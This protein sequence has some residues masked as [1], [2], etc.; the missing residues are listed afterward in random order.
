MMLMLRKRRCQ[1][2]GSLTLQKFCVL[3]KEMR[4]QRLV[5]T[6][7]CEPCEE[8]FDLYFYVLLFG[9]GRSCIESDSVSLLFSNVASGQES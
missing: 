5:L 1:N 8:I 4:N 6:T 9:L 3:S 7:T 2:R